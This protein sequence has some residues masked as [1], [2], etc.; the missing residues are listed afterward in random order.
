MKRLVL[1]AAVAALTAGCGI[2]PSVVIEG[3]AAPTEDLDGVV[4][5]FLNGGVLTRVTRTPV[6]P[7]KD[8][9]TLLGQGLTGMEQSQGLTTEVPAGAAPTTASDNGEMVTV[10]ISSPV[11]ELSS[12]AQDQIVCTAAPPW[13]EPRAQVVI[14]GPDQSTQPSVCPYRA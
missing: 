10:S 5:F 11:A 3:A 14:T 8:L 9:L 4:L 1:L 2:R 13:R 7:V 12:N 6:E